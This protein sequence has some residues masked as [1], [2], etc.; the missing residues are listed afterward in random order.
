MSTPE[1][2]LEKLIRTIGPGYHPDTP[3]DGYEPPITQYTRME[4]NRI[5]LRFRSE[6]TDPRDIYEFGL[7]IFNK[8]WEERKVKKFP[9]G[10]RSDQ[11][12]MEEV[13]QQVR[14][15]RQGL[16]HAVL[17]EVLDWSDAARYAFKRSLGE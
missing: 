7:D 3:Y 15:W 10:S 14:R 11:V 5:H 12:V 9:D 13:E 6:K 2:D 16:F 17:M 8:M 4:W 1:E